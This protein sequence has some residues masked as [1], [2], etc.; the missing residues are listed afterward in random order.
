MPTSL[1]VIKKYGRIIKNWTTSHGTGIDYVHATIR[2][3]WQALFVQSK[4]RLGYRPSF[5]CGERFFRFASWMRRLGNLPEE[6]MRIIIADDHPIV[7]VGLRLMLQNHCTDCQVI[8]EVHSSAALL[9]FLADH[10][11]DLVVTDFSMPADG[12]SLDGLEMLRRLRECHPRLGVIILTMS[13]NPALIR[14]MLAAGAKAVVEKTAMTK[15]LTLAVQTVRAGRSYVSEQL[16]RR[17][18][19]GAAESAVHRNGDEPAGVVLSMREAEIMRMLARGMTVTEI[20]KVTCRSIKTISQQKH[21]A[22]RKLCIDSDSQ[23]FEY[24][25]T[26]GI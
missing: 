23:L 5:V 9:A 18:A 22:M 19:G 20:A 3:P 16:R 17:L 6:L 13:S 1:R 11:C 26:H 21:D 4:A 12:E 2:V 10:P 25:R 14:G 8:G 24:M 15:E 7:L